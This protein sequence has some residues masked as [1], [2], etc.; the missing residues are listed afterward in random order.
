VAAGGYRAAFLTAAAL[1]ALG[2][3]VAA[4]S[5]RADERTARRA[6]TPDH[7]RP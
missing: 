5:R 1:A 4:L 3:V 6:W 7:R 2:L